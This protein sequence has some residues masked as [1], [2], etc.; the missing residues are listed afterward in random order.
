MKSKGHREN[1]LNK[2]YDEEG[3]GIVITEKGDIY[4]TENF[5]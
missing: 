1:I 2:D 5:F 4:I 3:I